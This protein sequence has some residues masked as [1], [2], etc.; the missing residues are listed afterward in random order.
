MADPRPTRT[1]TIY[2]KCLC[3]RTLH[4]I[5]EATRGECATCWIKH[6]SPDTYQAMQ[7]LILSAFNGST[8]AQKDAAVKDA[9]AAM[10]KGKGEA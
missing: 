5:N 7:R 1:V 4:S 2:D 3:G 8:D 6:L 10:E 9:F